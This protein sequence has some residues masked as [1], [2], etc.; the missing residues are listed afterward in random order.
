M[1]D[2]VSPSAIL[3]ILRGVEVGFRLGMFGNRSEFIFGRFE[4]KFLLDGK[5]QPKRATPI[6]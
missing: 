1:A 4:V 3:A 5:V 2:A 6:G